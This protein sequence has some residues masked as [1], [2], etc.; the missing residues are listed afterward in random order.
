MMN[1]IE[2]NFSPLRLNLLRAGYLLLIVGLGLNYWV[3]LATHGLQYELMEGV[4][5]ALLTALS[6]LAILGLRHPIKMLPLLLFE[7]VW[8]VLWMG[9]VA[10]RAWLEGPI[11]AAMGE[12]IFA[13][14][15][16]VIYLFLVPWSYVWR[17][18]IVAPGAK[19]R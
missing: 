14:S 10:L 17:A 1:E 6:L 8:K 12:V 15:I 9:F 16:G 2:Q 7:I 18:Y 3:G 19:W 13:C 4:V 5:V 11:D